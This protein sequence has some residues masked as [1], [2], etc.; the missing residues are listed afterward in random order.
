MVLR[1]LKN[2]V[3]L[4]IFY[5]TLELVLVDNTYQY[6]ICFIGAQNQ[7]SDVKKRADFKHSEVDKSKL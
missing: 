3:L 4:K 7:L 2:Y 6:L 5:R 1:F